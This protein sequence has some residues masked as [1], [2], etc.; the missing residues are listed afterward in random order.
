M[1][2]QVTHGIDIGHNRIIEILIMLY[3]WLFG[4]LVA[5]IS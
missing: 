5:S 4:V 1:S 2:L 3:V